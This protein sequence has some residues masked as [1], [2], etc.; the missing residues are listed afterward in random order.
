MVLGFNLVNRVVSKRHLWVLLPGLPL[1]LW[2]EEILELIANQLGKFM[3]VEKVSMC[4]E[5]RKMARVLV[6]LDISE[7]MPDSFQILWEDF[8]INQR[9][10]YKVIPLIFVICHETRHFKSD[11][12][13]GFAGN[14]LERRSSSS[15]STAIL[16]DI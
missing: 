3:S 15:T 14:N 8:I 2:S 1:Q 12:N 4:G 16:P 13:A 9:L 11:C 5:D 7:G 10:D 6:D